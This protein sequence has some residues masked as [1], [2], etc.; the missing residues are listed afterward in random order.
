MLVQEMLHAI[1]SIQY[2]LYLDPFLKTGYGLEVIHVMKDYN[3]FDIL[4]VANYYD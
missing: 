3:Y 2:F 4:H 1:I